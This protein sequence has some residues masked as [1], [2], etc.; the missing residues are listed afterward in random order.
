MSSF[1]GGSRRAEEDSVTS[2]FFLKNYRE[3]L[4]RSGIAKGLDIFSCLENS[5][6]VGVEC[7]W[8]WEWDLSSKFI[9]IFLVL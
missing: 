9:D 4:S 6:G 3:K 5:V 8:E 7:E 1:G 2:L